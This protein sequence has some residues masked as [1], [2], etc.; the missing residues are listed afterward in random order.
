MSRKNILIVDKDKD[1]LRELREGFFPYNNSY[2]VAFASSTAKAE[3]MLAKFAVDLVLANIHM[4]GESGIGLLLTIRRWHSD[5]HV[6]LYSDDLSEE[7]K[8]A[9]YYSGAAAVLDQ[10]FMFTA[11]LDVVATVLA[12]EPKDTFLETVPLVDLLQLIAMGK[13]SIDI[14]VIGSEKQRG[15]IRIQQGRLIGAEVGGERGVNA[16]SKLLSW[17]TPTI[18]TSKGSNGAAAISGRQSLQQ[19]LMQAVVKLDENNQ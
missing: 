18:K 3:E 7:L 1:F 5:T 9:A 12:K 13:H 16:I 10:P 14:M 4:A 19:V 17:Q 15:I 2:Q 8:R 6:I 11:L